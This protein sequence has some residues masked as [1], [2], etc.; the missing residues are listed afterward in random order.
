[1]RRIGGDE[2]GESGGEDVGSVTNRTATLVYE[3]QLLVM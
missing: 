1:M 3:F 2:V